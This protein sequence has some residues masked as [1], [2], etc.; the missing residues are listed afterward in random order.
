MV[1]KTTVQG[2]TYFQRVPLSGYYW[3]EMLTMRR[4]KSLLEDML[5]WDETAYCREYD[6]LQDEPALFLTLAETKGDRDSVLTF[7][8]KYGRLNLGPDPWIELARAQRVINTLEDYQSALGWLRQRVTIWRHAVAGEVEPLREYISWQRG[9]LVLRGLLDRSSQPV[10]EAGPPPG[11]EKWHQQLSQEISDRLVEDDVIGAAYS[12]VTREISLQLLGARP[13][14]IYLP[15]E[16]RVSFSFGIYTLWGAMMLQF[17]EAIAGQ[18]DYQRCAV[19]SRW[20]ELAPGV[21]RSDRTT[22]SDSCRQKR[23]KQRRLRALALH[24]EGKPPREI[25][26]EVGSDVQ[27]VRGWIERAREQ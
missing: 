3:R 13:S 26:R 17:A 14:L 12:F 22:C 10:T 27:T 24:A 7:V 2:H 23:Q 6:P 1:T 19:C 9:R 5:S 25:A 15:A 16:R 11:S 8:N 18:H 4:G 20:F 21:N